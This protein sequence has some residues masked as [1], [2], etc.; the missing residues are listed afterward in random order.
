MKNCGKKI[1]EF[2]KSQGIAKEHCTV[3]SVTVKK[4]NLSW[5]HFNGRKD[6]NDEICKKGFHNLVQILDLP[7]NKAFYETS[8][9]NCLL[10]QY[11]KDYKKIIR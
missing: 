5:L 11:W 7:K 6:E 4:M 9:V 1:D 2:Y 3:S 10:D 8:F